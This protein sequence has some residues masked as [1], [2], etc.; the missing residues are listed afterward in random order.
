MFRKL[1]R[2]KNEISAEEAKQLLKNNKRAAFSV[3]GD[4]GYPYTIPIKMCIRDRI[5]AAFLMTAASCADGYVRKPA[6]I[7]APVR[8]S[9]AT[10]R[11]MHV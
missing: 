4:D 3:H 10:G 8:S 5:S 6:C 9:A 7:S 11:L 1:R 2:V